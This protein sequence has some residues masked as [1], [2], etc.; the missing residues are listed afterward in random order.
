MVI[1]VI[2]DVIP[3]ALDTLATAQEPGGEIAKDVGKHIV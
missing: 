3:G 2:D 1:G